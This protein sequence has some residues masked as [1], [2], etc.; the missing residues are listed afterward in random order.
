MRLR[1]T[2]LPEVAAH[3]GWTKVEAIESLMRKAGYDGAITEA[4]RESVNLTRYQSTIFTMPYSDYIS[5]IKATRGVAPSFAGAKL[6][7]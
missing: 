7:H 4:L 6:N 3:E 5:Y 2:Y 1:A